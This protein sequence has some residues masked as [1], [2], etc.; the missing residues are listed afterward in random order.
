[1]ATTGSIGQLFTGWGPYTPPA[2]LS[3]NAARFGQFTGIATPGN[4]D[5]I[6]SVTGPSGLLLEVGKNPAKIYL[7]GSSADTPVW[8]NLK[9]VIADQFNPGTETTGLLGTNAI[10]IQ[11]EDPSGNI[12]AA[13][14]YLDSTQTQV[15]AISLCQAESSSLFTPGQAVTFRG[16]DTGNL[17]ANTAPWQPVLAAGFQIVQSGVDTLTGLRQYDNKFGMSLAM[18]ARTGEPEWS[19]RLTTAF[20]FNQLDL[21]GDGGVDTNTLDEIMGECVSFMTNYL[22]LTV[23]ELTARNE[24][25]KNLMN[26]KNEALGNK[27]A[28]TEEIFKMPPDRVEQIKEF[29][30]WGGYSSYIQIIDDSITSQTALTANNKMQV[31]AIMDAV[32]EILSQRVARDTTR[33]QVLSSMQTNIW[34]ILRDCMDR[35]RKVRQ[36][37]INRI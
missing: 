8:V 19:K 28:I 10:T 3:S 1:M 31:V 11:F 6:F 24:Q 13:E 9:D 16:L 22:A 21:D 5:V 23:A 15:T 7:N 17:Q 4:P 37:A 33:T 30:R 26:A 36:N 32:I 14:I 25:L 29:F 18:Y 2:G 27:A 35:H 34:Q 20:T 12:T